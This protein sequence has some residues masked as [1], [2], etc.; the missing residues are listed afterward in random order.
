Q[1]RA[2]GD[3]GRMIPLSDGIGAQHFPIVNVAL[4]VANFAGFCS[5][6]AEQRHGGQLGGRA[7]I[8]RISSRTSATSSTNTA[9]LIAMTTRE[10]VVA[11][12]LHICLTTP[13]IWH[14]PSSTG[15]DSGRNLRAASG[16]PLVT[17]SVTSAH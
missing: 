6:A 2:A 3:G 13:A 7:K 8:R 9:G 16:G 4:I 10:S 1:H 15:L 17:T 11:A 5:A 12:E 14:K